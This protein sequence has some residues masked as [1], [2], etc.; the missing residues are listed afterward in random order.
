[1]LTYL[2]VYCTVRRLLD[3]ACQ[4][5]LVLADYSGGRYIKCLGLHTV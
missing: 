4:R 2:S 3:S 1:M 5:V